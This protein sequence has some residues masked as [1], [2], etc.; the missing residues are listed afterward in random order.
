MYRGCCLAAV[1]VKGTEREQPLFLL[2]LGARGCGRRRPGGF[3][4]YWLP[5]SIGTGRTDT[6]AA[7]L[8]GQIEAHNGQS[9]KAFEPSTTKVEKIEGD[10]IHGREE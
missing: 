2:P 7:L 6:A 1:L 8:A 9:S 10:G 3:R 4:K 5:D